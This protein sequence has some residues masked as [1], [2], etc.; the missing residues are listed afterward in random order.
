MNILFDIL[1]SIEIL[2]GIFII[3]VATII[4]VASKDDGHNRHG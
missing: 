2:L 1:C 3:C 4:L